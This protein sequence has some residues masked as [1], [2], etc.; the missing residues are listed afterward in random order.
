MT[1]QNS[2]VS[3]GGP[4]NCFTPSQLDSPITSQGHNIDSGVTCG[5]TASGDMSSTG[6]L[7]GPLADN[8]GPTRT[9]A[10]LLGSPAI[11]TAD[12]AVCPATDQRGVARPQLAACDIGAFER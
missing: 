4:D 8:G 9:R 7:L 12:N 10:L 3:G 2:I 1:V 11:D 6:P 5:F